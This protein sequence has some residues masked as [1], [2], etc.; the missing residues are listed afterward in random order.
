MNNWV[1]MMAVVAVL[2][3]NSVVAAEAASPKKAPKHAVTSTCPCS[4][5]HVCVGPRG[6]RYCITAG[7]KKRYMKR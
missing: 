6:G 1:A 5:A 7:G 4:G 3:V 2:G